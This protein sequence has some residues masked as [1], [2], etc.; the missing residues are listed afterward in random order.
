MEDVEAD[1]K[2]AQIQEKTTCQKWTLKIKRVLIQ[3]IFFLYMIFTVWA[4]SSSVKLG[5]TASKDKNH[6]LHKVSKI[7]PQITL[8]IVTG[9]ASPLFKILT[10]LENYSDETTFLTILR[11]NTMVKMI[12]ILLFVASLI[13]PMQCNNNQFFQKDETCDETCEALASDPS[14]TSSS[15]TQTRSK[16]A[17]LAFQFGISVPLNRTGGSVLNEEGQNIY[18]GFSNLCPTVSFWSF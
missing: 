15:T 11:R 14:E 17:D 9:A 6:I 1:E 10:G 3:I 4:I 13:V 18:S 12:A 2:K 8:S 7:I 5:R 16:V